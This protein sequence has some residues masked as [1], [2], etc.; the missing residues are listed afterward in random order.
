VKIVFERMV[1]M[2]AGFVA[3][4]VPGAT[5]KKPASGLIA[6]LSICQTKEEKEETTSL[7]SS[8]SS[9]LHPGNVVSNGVHLPSWQS[10]AQHG[11]IRL[12]T[13]GRESGSNV[14]RATLWRGESENQH[15]LSKPVD[16]QKKRKKKIP[17]IP[18]LI[19]SLP[20][21]P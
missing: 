20:F 2:A 7:Q 13:G 16:Y 6:Y 15:V 10:G 18:T 11:Q 3:S 14:I 17:N 8:I 12:A 21:A 19:T 4:E 1:A 5:P 9:K